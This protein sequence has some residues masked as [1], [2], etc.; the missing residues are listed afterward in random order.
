MRGG[1][2]DAGS[3]ISRFGCVAFVS[4]KQKMIRF[5]RQTN[6]RQTALVAGGNFSVSYNDNGYLTVL[7][8]CSNCFNV[9]KLPQYLG[10]ITRP[11]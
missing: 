7:L 8:Y 3:D 9:A 10:K 4:I 2:I 6:Q 1:Q 5:S 11:A